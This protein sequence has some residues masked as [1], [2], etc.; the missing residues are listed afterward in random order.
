MN[1]LE[2]RGNTGTL[3]SQPFHW[4]TRATVTQCLIRL[5]A[6]CYRCIARMV[7]DLVKVLNHV[8]FAMKI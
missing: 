4:M 2:Y 8:K 1:W 3:V 7:A 6:A 5:T